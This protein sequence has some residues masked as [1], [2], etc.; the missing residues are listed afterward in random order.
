MPEL[1]RVRL[2]FLLGPLKHNTDEKSS[3]NTLTLGAKN[4]VPPGLVTLT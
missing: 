1:F 2:L 4:F 3:S